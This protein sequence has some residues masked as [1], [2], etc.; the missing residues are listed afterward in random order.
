MLKICL[1]YD[2]DSILLMESLQQKLS[3]HEGLVFQSYN[4]GYVTEKKKARS[5]KGNFAAK[6][7]PFC[8]LYEDAKMVKGFYSEDGRCTERN[9]L[10]HLE[11]NYGITPGLLG[12]TLGAHT[13]SLDDLIND[14]RQRNNDGTRT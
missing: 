3:G 8:G 9:I 7:T 1:C 4:E 5:I 10:S 6:E 12:C 13:P 14:F 2:R 11:E